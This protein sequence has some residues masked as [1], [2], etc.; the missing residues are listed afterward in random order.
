[1]GD[2]GLN[3][4]KLRFYSTFKSCFRPEFYVSNIHNRGQRAWLSRLRTSS[5]HL[6]VEVQ[7]YRGI[8]LHE[9][10]CRYCPPAAED[11]YG[12]VGDE[13]HFLHDC[14]TFSNQ[15]RC[16]FAKL[17]CVLPAFSSMSR[18]DKVKT[19]LCPVSVM[20]AKLINKFIGLMFKA[21]D[22]IEDGFHPSVLT[23]P[24]SVKTYCPPDVDLSISDSLSDI[25]FDETYRSDVT[26]ESEFELP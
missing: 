1:V 16:L 8:P 17:S 10:H 11:Q 7:R 5:H 12:R 23:F 15:R 21:R 26:L 22:K 25:D 19:M 6:E 13:S 9:R 18:E 14:V 4:N 2:D 20:A 24:P 3:H